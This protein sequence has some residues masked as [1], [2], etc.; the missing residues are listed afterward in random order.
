MYALGIDFG[1]SGARAVVLDGS[2]RSP[3]DSIVAQ[4]SYRFSNVTEAASSIVWK[5]VLWQLIEAIAPQVRTQ[6]YRIAINATSG[7]MLLCDQTG[8]PLTQALMY[9]DAIARP[10]LPELSAVAPADS[11]TLSATSTLAKAM[12]LYH[13]EQY[14]GYFA[15]RLD[16]IHIA[17]QADWIAACLH[18]QAPISD[19]HNALKLGYDVRALAYPDW[20]VNLPI[21]NWLP[22]VLEPGKAIAPIRS[23]LA[24]QY[25]LPP[26]CQVCAGTT[27]SIAAFLASG[28]RYPGEA[29]TSLGSTLV[30]KLLS[31][32]DISSQSY[33]IYSHRLGN[34]WLVGG[35]S[36]TGGSVLRQYFS[37]EQIAE[38]STQIDL[39]KPCELAYYP[40]IEPG[41]RFPI[42]DPDYPPQLTPRPNRDID[43]LYEM[44]DAIARIESEG[45][46][47][48][49]ALGAPKIKR[50]YTAGGGAQNQTWRDIRQQKLG[51]SVVEALQTEAA[52]GTAN[53][54][55]KGLIDFCV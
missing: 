24:T 31:Q 11:P 44:L 21:A 1:T 27:D 54:A 48:L 35:A 52:Y 3:S 34:L 45:Y 23:D 17:H 50:V 16:H 40:L 42:N 2:S 9:N 14:A 32:V 55:L 15:S 7:T 4:A 5:Q 10:I 41:E 28:A 53:L 39:S 12:W 43:F 26:S 22:E 19:Y 47:K 46:Q 37:S 18:G 30:L 36:N 49:Q 33:G 51:V 13:S 38:L 6:I 29:V 25:D 20:L 8:Q